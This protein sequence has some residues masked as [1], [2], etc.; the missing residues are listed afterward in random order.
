MKIPVKA[1]TIKKTDSFLSFKIK[2]M[3]KNQRDAMSAPALVEF[4]P[5][6]SPHGIVQFFQYVARHHGPNKMAK[7]PSAKVLVS[8]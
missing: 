5:Q 6:E 3:Q 4:V 1:N 2:E 8:I 7:K